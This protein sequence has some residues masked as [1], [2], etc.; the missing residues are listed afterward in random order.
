MS[1]IFEDTNLLYKIFTFLDIQDIC[2]LK[3]VNSHFK[4][5]AEEIDILKY[6]EYYASFLDL[7]HHVYEL[8]L[9]NV[10]YLTI[11]DNAFIYYEFT[12]TVLEKYKIILIREDSFLQSLFSFLVLFYPYVRT[13]FYF[14]DVQE[15]II[16]YLFI[17]DT[18]QK[19]TNKILRTYMRY[20]YP[21]MPRNKLY[22][23]KR[24]YMIMKLTKNSQVI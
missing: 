23:M 6:T 15:R 3:C 14:E 22:K 18:T 1:T 8:I 13:T 17:T 10:L 21:I 24:T 11:V 9:N 2:K 4:Q 20:K 12:N 5:I 16:P 7:K 19:I